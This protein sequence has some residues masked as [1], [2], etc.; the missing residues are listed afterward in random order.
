VNQV[1]QLLRNHDV[2]ALQE[3]G[4]VPPLDPN[5]DFH[6]QDSTT[7]NGYTLRDF[8]HDPVMLRHVYFLETDPNGHRNNLT[9]VTEVEVPRGRLWITPPPAPTIRPDRWPARPAVRPIVRLVAS[10]DP[11][12][13]WRRV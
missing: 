8:G 6:C 12:Q 3:T 5:G 1:P 2:L 7:V 10:A 9:M 13:S 11:V 4:P